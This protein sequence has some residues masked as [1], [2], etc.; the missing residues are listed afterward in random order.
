MP[1]A[2]RFRSLA[3]VPFAALGLML[4][5]SGSPSPAR[6]DTVILKNG[7]IYQG[8]VDR[9]NTMV[10]V[11]DNLKR[12]IFYDSKIQKVVPD[13]GF[14]KLERFELIQPMEVHAG[15]QPPAAVD[16]RVTPWDSKGRRA[17]RYMND[18]QQVVEMHQAIR[19]LGV[20]LTRF[21]GIDG[22]WQ[23]Q[24]ATSQVPRSVVI[25]L[26]A[27]VDQKNEDE[28]LKVTRWLIQSAWY[29]EARTALD[30]LERDFPARKE[31][32]DD[33]RR[34]IADLEARDTLQEVAFRRKALQPLAVAKLLGSLPRTGLA[35]DILDDV[36][37]QLRKDDDQAKAD[38][39]LADSL[40]DL[41]EKL[42]EADRKAWRG[43]LAE[44]LEGLAKAPDA[45]RTRLEAVGRVEAAA[46]PETRFALAMT[47]WIVGNESATDNLKQ[48]DDSWRAR[49]LVARYLVARDEATRGNLLG[50]LEKVQGIDLDALARLVPRVAPPLRDKDEARE[51]P[52][53]VRIHR[54]AED[55]NPEPSEYAVLLPPEYHPLRSYPAV[56]ALHDGRG[57]R[58]AVEWLA[59]E[60]SKRGY[61]VIAPEYN[62]PGRGKAYRY[63]SSEQAAAILSIRD[64]RKRYAINSDRIYLAGQLE[65]ANMAWDFGLGH[66]DLF[67]GVV[68]ISGFPAK[69][70]FKYKVQLDKLPVYTAL[71]EMAP[72]SRELIFDQFARPLIEAGR[73][74][75]YVDY[76]KRG[77]EELPEEVPAFFDW[78]DRRTRE[79]APKA[80]EVATAREEDNRFF[81]V[82]LREFAPGRIVSPEAADPLGKNIRP[83]TL[84]MRT[85]TEANSIVVTT[86]GITKLDVWV[87]PKYIDF[88][89][90]LIIRLND[91]PFFS[92]II[93]QDF[94][95]MLE[96]LRVRGDRQQLYYFKAVMGQA[97]PRPKGR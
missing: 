86:S 40:R 80:F 87:G 50:D 25:G 14:S 27:G 57:P 9:D 41:A 17:F 23:G 96:D 26:L 52:G 55:D 1:A 89:K 97:G 2:R 6:A 82:I 46:S 15:I 4:A 95:P 47:G 18:R 8:T 48:A 77:L 67:A 34:S 58:P 64:A 84:K 42:P 74:I 88:K 43:R 93:K 3:A 30:G 72:A 62:I 68:A 54:V 20:H 83:A 92:G 69:Y 78:M 33:V 21:R 70:A 81:G 32:I 36:R 7:A 24:V 53:E 38:R 71:G 60:A 65:G 73:D 11:N 13:A 76:L 28:R 12:V 10:F 59:A 37:E 45:A 49:D 90:R 51:K 61:I 75:T 79:P 91:R 16:I 44:V 29:P 63:S 31:S 35:G 19:E 85:S 56:V 22:F 39:S 94:G 5:A 66:P